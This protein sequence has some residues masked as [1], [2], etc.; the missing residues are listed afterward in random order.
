MHSAKKVAHCANTMAPLTFNARFDILV[1]RSVLLRKG[2]NKMELRTYTIAGRKFLACGRACAD[3][4][5]EDRKH[6]V[7]H[8]PYVDEH[9]EYYRNA[10]EASLKAEFCAYCG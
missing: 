6:G 7:I 2:R 8:G 5:K 4:F 10:E 3:G 9:G 1:T